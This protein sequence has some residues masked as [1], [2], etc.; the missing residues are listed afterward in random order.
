MSATITAI[1]DERE[2]HG[3]WDTGRDYTIVY[4]MMMDHV[5]DTEFDASA[6]FQAATGIQFYTAEPEDSH[7][8]CRDIH[9]L[10]SK[11]RWHILKVQ[12][13]TRF[14][15]NEAAGGKPGSTPSDPSSRDK[16]PSARPAVWTFDTTIVKKARWRDLGPPDPT[17]PDTYGTPKA[18]LNTSQQGMIPPWEEEIPLLNI[19]VNKNYVSSAIDLNDFAYWRN[20]CNYHAWN[21]L[22]PFTVKVENVSAGSAQLENGFPYYSVNWSFIVDDLP[23]SDGSVGWHITE[24]LNQ[25]T[26]G[27]ISRTVSGHPVVLGGP[28]DLR[29]LIDPT[30]AIPITAPVALSA[31]SKMLNPGD[32][33]NY[34]QFYLT[35]NA[36]FS[37]IPGL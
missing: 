36:D 20:R 2:A 6:V 34:L 1:W 37:G 19:K 17:T 4:R 21:G 23:H 31:N 29:Q 24:F 35:R 13:A 10:R 16:N 8:H 28:A 18:L 12:Y 32:T 7:A 33:P 5:S 15:M 9:V 22:D 3:S 26:I 11:G 30:S 25:G 27:W 14:A